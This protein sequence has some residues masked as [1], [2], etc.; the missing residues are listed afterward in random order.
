[1]T[2]CSVNAWVIIPS[3]LVIGGI[4]S[5]FLFDNL[6]EPGMLRAPLENFYRFF[7]VL[8]ALILLPV[9][10]LQSIEQTH[11]DSLIIQEVLR[12]ALGS[13][14]SIRIQAGGSRQERHWR[15]SFQEAFQELFG[16]FV[17]QSNTWG[18][19]SLR[20][21]INFKFNILRSF[22]CFVLRHSPSHMFRSLKKIGHASSAS[23]G[24]VWL[25]DFS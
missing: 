2:S 16:T 20:S 12:S 4:V 23:N 6:I 10:E 17:Q 1:M 7:V 14:L 3:A 11:T 13:N 8:L 19:N 24:V 22:A 21:C 25:E 5:K 18:R 15:T 9:R